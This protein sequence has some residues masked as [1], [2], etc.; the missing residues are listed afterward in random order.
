MRGIMMVLVAAVVAFT[1]LD[2]G[3]AKCTGKADCKACKNCKHCAHC[4]A[5]GT[6]GVCK[7]PAP[8]KK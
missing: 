1:P 5:G 3:A 6:C 7:P 2:A 8:P 4:K